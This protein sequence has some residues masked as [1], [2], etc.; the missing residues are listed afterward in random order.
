MCEAPT[1]F[2]FWTADPL[3]DVSFASVCV[4]VYVSVCVCA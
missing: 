1:D 2:G 4:R 3:A